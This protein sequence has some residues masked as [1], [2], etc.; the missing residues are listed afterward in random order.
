VTTFVMVVPGIDMTRALGEQRLT[1]K[2]LRSYL[3]DH[4]EKDFRISGSGRYVNGEDCI[5]YNLVLEVRRPPLNAL[6]GLVEFRACE[7]TED[8]LWGYEAVVP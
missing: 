4:P 2:W 6:V 3:A 7:R 8:N 5:R 1:K